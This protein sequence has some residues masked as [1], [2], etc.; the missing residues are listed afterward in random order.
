M[1]VLNKGVEYVT[2][3]NYKNSLTS[4]SRM[5]IITFFFFKKKVNFIKIV[6]CVY[7]RSTFWRMR[8]AQLQDARVEMGNFDS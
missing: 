2:D 6:P 5:A 1:Y 3:S 4:N 7:L 8:R